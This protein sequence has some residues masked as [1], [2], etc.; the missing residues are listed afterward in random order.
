MSRRRGDG[1]FQ[2]DSELAYEDALQLLVT[3][4]QGCA[5][6]QST[7]P[8]G[9]R[10][11]L[12]VLAVIR[13]QIQLQQAVAI[14]EYTRRTERATIQLDCE[15]NTHSFFEA[16]AELVRRGILTPELRF[17]PNSGEPS[18]VRPGGFWVTPYGLEWAGAIGT[19]TILPV[20]HE[21]F[22]DLLLEHEPRFGRVFAIR[23]SE[24]VTAYRQQLYLSC[25]TM[26]GGAAEEVFEQLAM[27]RTG[28]REAHRKALL[29]PRKPLLT[30]VTS[31][32]PKKESEPLQLY[33][34]ALKYWRDDAAHANE[35]DFDERHAFLSLLRL[36]R[37]AE[38][39]DRE[40]AS[41][42]GHL[43]RQGQP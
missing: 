31:R 11:Y 21:R 18:A 34:E 15:P 38:M 7:V 10:A 1:W 4:L 3:K 29:N 40:W 20:Q 5:V 2:L 32:L 19:L 17:D 6:I 30:F 26:C 24:A 27:T 41:L 39:V 23:C 35:R 42:V 36:A 8:P 28:N 16:A 13:E 22:L 33:G 37:L 14:E 25:L 12:S 43:S 9:G